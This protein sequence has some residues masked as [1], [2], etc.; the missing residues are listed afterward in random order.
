MIIL[1]YCW[2]Q[3]L[4]YLN[5]IGFQILWVEKWLKCVGR[6]SCWLVF[7]LRGV[8]LNSEGSLSAG[9]LQGGHPLVESPSP[10]NTRQI[11][12]AVSTGLRTLPFCFLLFC[13]V[14]FFGGGLPSEWQ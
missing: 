8:H 3:G 12:W 13:F 10:Q 7:L 4:N 2:A 6:G 1:N 14:F 5:L 11:F 9:Q